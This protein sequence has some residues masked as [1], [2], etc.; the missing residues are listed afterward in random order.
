MEGGV[1]DLYKASSFDVGKT[2]RRSTSLDARSEFMMTIAILRDFLLWC[3]IVNYAALLSWFLAFTFAH[4]SLYQLH[5][6]WF[7]LSANQ[8][9]VIHYS[10]M[11]VYKIAALSLNLAPYIALRIATNHGL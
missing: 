8:F 10:G 2:P 7:R 5:A 6:R 9:D 4:R 1:D 3:A 11:A